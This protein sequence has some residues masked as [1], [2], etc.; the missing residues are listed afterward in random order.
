[1]ISRSN[2]AGLDETRLLFRE[3][4]FLTLPPR[5]PVDVELEH[6]VGVAERLPPPRDPP[7]APPRAKS[8]FRNLLCN[9]SGSSAVAVLRKPRYVLRSREPDRESRIGKIQ[10]GGYSI[11][12]GL[13]FFRFSILGLVPEIS[14]RIPVLK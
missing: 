13:Y 7:R 10:T 2:A 4:D 6:A 11:L 3:S 12:S 9:F 1:M 5:L 8:D 14:G